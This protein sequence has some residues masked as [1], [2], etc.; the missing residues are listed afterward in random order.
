[1]FT[2]P[3]LINR[4][5]LGNIWAL[6]MSLLTLFYAPELLGQSAD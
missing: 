2:L 6:L 4:I 1:M 3:K 5:W